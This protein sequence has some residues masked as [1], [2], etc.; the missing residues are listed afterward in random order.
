MLVGTQIYWMYIF[1]SIVLITVIL[2]IDFFYFY[3][4]LFIYWMLFWVLSSLYTLQVC[5][6]SLTRFKY[7]KAF[8]SCYF[9]SNWEK[10]KDKFWKVCI[11]IYR[12]NES[13][14]NISSGTGNTSDGWMSAIQF[15]T[16]PKDDLPQYSYISG[17]PEPLKTETSNVD[18]YRMVNMLHLEIQNGKEAM[19]TFIFQKH[20]WGTE[21]CMKRIM[22]P[23]KGW[24]QLTSDDTYF[25]DSCFSGA[26]MAGQAITEGVDYF[27]TVKTSPKKFCLAT[28]RKFEERLAGM[29]KTSH[30]K[31]W[32]ATMGNFY[33]RLTA[34]L[35]CYEE[36]PKRYW[37]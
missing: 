18:C 14:R 12:F 7:F 6:I 34:R 28:R 33:E 19:K 9:T 27:G 17:N 3:T 2:G 29:V 8:C 35:S 11:L 23:I 22:M 36:Y 10:G 24:D 13:R 5:V 1:I 15:C 25:S 21:E 31:F 4:T 26:K 30:K 16:A 20:L 37:W 32:L